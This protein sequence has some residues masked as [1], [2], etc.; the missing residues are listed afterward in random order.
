[1]R[2]LEGFTETFAV[3]HGLAA[4]DKARTLIVLEELLTNLSK[5]GYPDQR[6][7]NGIA[8]VALDWRATG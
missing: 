5:Y 2:E 7:P 8:E 4:S 3:E 1:M 6:E